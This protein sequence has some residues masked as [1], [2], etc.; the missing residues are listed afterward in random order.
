MLKVGFI[1]LGQISN[2]NVLGYL[3]SNDAEIVAVC[4][5]DEMAAAQWLRKWTLSNARW[6][7]RC[8]EMLEKQR[9]DIV[10]ILTPH[11]LHCEHALK[12]AQSGVR[13]ISLQKPM[14][15]TLRE[16]RQIIEACKRHKVKLK[17]YENFV[18]Y[19]VY[20]KAKE[21]IGQGLIGD[22]ASIRVHTMVGIRDGAPWPWCFSPNTW[23]TDL[24]TS[25]AG[26][27]V[28]DDG[29]HKFSLARWFME[30]D[31]DKVSAWIEPETPLDAPA[32]IRARFKRLPGDSPKYAQIDFSFSPRMAL[33]CDFWLDEFVEI[34]GER[35][36]MWLNQC[37]A[38][39]DR[40]MFRG[41]QMSQSRVFPPIAVFVGGKVSTYLEEMPLSERNWSSSFVASTKHFIKAMRD[42][43]EPV[44]TG[45]QGMEIT[46][47][48]MAAYVSAQEQR[49]VYLDEIT[50]EAEEKKEFQIKT[51]FCNLNGNNSTEPAVL[52]IGR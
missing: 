50:L 9:F 22:L 46:R 51:N 1:G 42:S 18:F 32:M 25:G 23:R 26:P 44:Y 21:L 41:N 49:D 39:G 19:P 30:R 31:L 14:A 4:S 29:F 3:N 40:G 16:C 12:C 35:G 38:A 37:S 15:I 48:A 45:E 24:R 36:I 6:Y 7:A 11:H 17:V 8:E 28:G 34:V 27:L 20:V 47:Y 2:E 43:G 52:A 5:T 10:E 13:G 33:P